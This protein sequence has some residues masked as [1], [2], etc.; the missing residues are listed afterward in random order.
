MINVSHAGWARIRPTIFA[1]R[2]ARRSSAL[3]VGAFVAVLLAGS[4]AQ[5]Q[6]TVS[7]LTGLSAAAPV[8][9][10]AAGMA[11]AN[12]SASVGALVTS[13][14]SVNTAFLTQSSAFV[15]SPPN[16]Q[17]DQEGGGVWARG[18]GGHLNVGTTATAGNI[19]FGTPQQ[20]NI[21]CNTRTQED[22]AGVQIGTDFARLN[23]NGWN[24]HVGSTVGYLGSRTQDATPGLNPPANFRDSLQIPFV[25]LYG[26]AS[27]GG[28]LVDAQ[29]RGDFFQNEVSDDNHGISGQQF[30]ARGV[31][32]TGNVAYNQDIGNRWFVEPSA[33]FVWSKNRVDQLNV[34]GTGIGGV[35]LGPGFV[36]PWVLTVNDIESVLGRLGVRVGTTVT[37]GDVTWQPFASASVFHEFEG[38][39]TSNLTSNFSALGAAFAPLPSLSSTVTTSGLGT[40]GQFGLGIAARS[41]S[42]DWVS[43]LRADYRTGDNI[44]GWS[45]NGGVR[46]QFVP[47]PGAAGPR[48]AVKAP[49]YKAPAS[50]VYHWSG[51]YVGAYVG[52]DWGS[53]NWTFRDDG[54]TTNPRFAG[55]LGGGEIGY[56]HQ[57]NKWVFGIEGDVAWTN[58]RGA[59][60]CSI[61]FFADCEI[62]SSWLSTVTGR[63]GYAYWDR[64]L[65]Y[66]KGGVAIAEDR[67]EAACT[68]DSASPILPVVGCPSQSDTKTRLGW[69]AGLGTEFGLTRN[70]SVKSEIMYFDLGSDRYT[71]AGIPTDIERSGFISNVGLHF[72]FGG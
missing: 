32:L 18:V 24:L 22:F 70:V 30:N 16:P 64:L 48:L 13:I 39:V 63:V 35:P 68:A 11:V 2:L 65:T 3:S 58:T 52:A 26:A 7:G 21:V 4:A 69:T 19:S 10:Q 51:Y 60:P 72:R 47:D 15:G 12:V 62:G 45:V 20:G 41:A 38:G 66:V 57:I 46:Y 71:I 56:N 53:T 40:Y 25:G 33:G 59:R 42:S 6:C 23:V 5:A 27:Y 1:D 49:V 8:V 50:Q 31:S 44:D 9:A 34:P 14:N 37:S 28:F 17:P 67:A 61:G 43:Y 54:G 29:L 36:P 55:F